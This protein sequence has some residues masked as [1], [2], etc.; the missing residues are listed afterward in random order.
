MERVAG[1]SDITHP[2]GLWCQFPKGHILVPLTI[3]L[4]AGIVSDLE[5]PQES[6]QTKALEGY[7]A[8]PGITVHPFT[9]MREVWE[10]GPAVAPK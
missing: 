4:V 5:R 7:T 2:T 3:Y 8:D 1:Q 9:Q 6:F 10:P